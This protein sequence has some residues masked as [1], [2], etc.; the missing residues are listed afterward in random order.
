MKEI[1]SNAEDII[2]KFIMAA[3][4][5]YILND[6]DWK[7]LFGAVNNMYPEF[8]N[9]IQNKFQRIKEPML[10]VCYLMKIGLTNPQITNI[11]NV[12]PQTAW[13]RIKTINDKMG[14]SFQINR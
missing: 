1:S 14:D 9:E 5:K 3:N 2:E 11:T 8:L 4:G 13:Y 10:R 6:E 7:D 12:P